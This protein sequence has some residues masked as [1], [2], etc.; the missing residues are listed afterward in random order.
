[1]MKVSEFKEY[2][3]SEFPSITFYN[4]AIDK[5]AKQCVGL[6]AR[7]SGTPNIAIGGLQNT[8]YG[9]LPVTLLVHWSEN[10]DTCEGIA[11]SLYEHLHGLSSVTMD[12][13]KV[14]HVRLLDP[15]PV[16]INRDS[17]NICE[18]VI[19]ANI[20]YEREVS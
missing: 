4:G 17:N 12:E 19:R 18:M 2:L 5:S 15:A 20:F 1:M 11:N 8:S 14:Y 16:G 3:E 9:T 7:G 13:R 10:S 6:Y